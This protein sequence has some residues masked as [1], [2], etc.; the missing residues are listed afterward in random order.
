[1]K[2]KVTLDGAGP[3]KNAPFDQGGD[4]GS[5][6]MAGEHISWRTDVQAVMSDV[7]DQPH[8]EVDEVHQF[9]PFYGAPEGSNTKSKGH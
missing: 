5:G 3:V 1:M 6:E 4:S 7:W 9:D 8:E 2:S